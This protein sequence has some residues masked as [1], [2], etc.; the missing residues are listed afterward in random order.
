MF[1][2]FEHSGR[3]YFKISSVVVFKTLAFIYH[4]LF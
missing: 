1:N 4:L 3:K 2:M